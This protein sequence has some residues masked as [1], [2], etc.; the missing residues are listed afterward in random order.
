VNNIKFLSESYGQSKSRAFK[1]AP[2]ISS[3]LSPPPNAFN[4]LIKEPKSS[5]HYNSPTS[6]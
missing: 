3:Q 5:P 1:K 6:F 4:V 2:E